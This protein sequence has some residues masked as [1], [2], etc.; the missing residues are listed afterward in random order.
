MKEFSCLLVDSCWQYCNYIYVSSS[1]FPQLSAEYQ[2]SEVYWKRCLHWPAQAGIFVS[3]LVLH[4]YCI[5]FSKH[6][7]ALQ[8][9]FVQSYM[10]LLQV[11][12]FLGIPT[13]C[14]NA[15][16][17]N[18]SSFVI[19]LEFGIHLSSPEDE[20][21]DSD[22]HKHTAASTFNRLDTAARSSSWFC[23]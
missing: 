1:L 11:L 19:Y 20:S 3:P 9:R 8:W 15:N 23:N 10:T 5:I 12:H 21:W 16:G 18:K 13:V 22:V 2:Q 6:S 4:A 14:N 7:N 17:V